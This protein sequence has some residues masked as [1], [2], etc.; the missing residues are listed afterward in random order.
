MKML[1]RVAI[2]NSIALKI[3][4]KA[5]KDGSDGRLNVT[6]EFPRHPWLAVLVLKG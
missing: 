2:Q 1:D 4:D 6:L 3:L 5:I